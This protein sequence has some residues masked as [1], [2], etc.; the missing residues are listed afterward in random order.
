MH[1]GG[2]RTPPRPKSTRHNAEAFPAAT[3]SSLELALTH[4][5]PWEEIWGEPLRLRGST[6][7]AIACA[8][9]HPRPARTRPDFRAPSPTWPRKC[10]P[11]P[12]PPGSNTQIKEIPLTPPEWNKSGFK[13]PKQNKTTRRNQRKLV[14]LGKCLAASSFASK[15]R[16]AQNVSIF[17]KN[18]IELSLK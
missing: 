10:H 17:S 1:P 11:T 8:P 9:G 13:K 18:A 15:Q 16:F 14:I 7:P 3:A 4:S 12:P 5:P 6:C 2:L